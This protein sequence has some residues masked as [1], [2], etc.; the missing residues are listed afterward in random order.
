MADSQRTDNGL[1]G[2]KLGTK[3]GFFEFF[4]RNEKILDFLFYV[5]H[6]NIDADIAISLY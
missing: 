5:F 3:R 2:L 6:A 1:I 4:Y